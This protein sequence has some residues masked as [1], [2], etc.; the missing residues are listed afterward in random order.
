MNDTFLIPA[1]SKKS[2]KI[3]GLFYPIDLIILG[4]G[5]LITFI[6]MV[7]INIGNIALAIIAIL[8]VSI[9]GFLVF[10]VPSYHNVRLF[11][12]SVWTFF[13]TRR[14]FIWKGWCVTDGEETSKK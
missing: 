2:M 6:L 12:V 10:P 9:A 5:I 13:T 3:F 11:L 4:V 1:N 8:P 7:T 14:T